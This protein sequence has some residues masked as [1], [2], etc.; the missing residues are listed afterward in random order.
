[1]RWKQPHDEDTRTIHRFLWL[2]RTISDETRWLE[3]ATIK[4][5]YVVGVY[6][7][8]WRDMHWMGK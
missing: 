7:R 1:M 4:Q 6:R 2:P 5:M 8:G 3:W